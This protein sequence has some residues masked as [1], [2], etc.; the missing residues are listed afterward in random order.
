VSD[1]VLPYAAPRAAA[2]PRRRSALGGFL[3]VLAIGLGVGL[4]ATYYSVSRNVV[5]GAVEAGPWTAWPRTGALDADP[6]TRASVARNGE[7]PLGLGEGLVFTARRDSAGRPLLA[8]C[9]YRVVGRA[10]QARYWTITAQT[11]NGQ[12][13]DNPAGRYGFTS[14]EIVRG[15]N[16]QFAIEVAREARPGAWLPVTGAGRFDLVMRLYDTPVSV[17]SRVI[18][19]ATAPRI[20]QVGC[21]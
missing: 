5:F 16:G 10:P 11:P 4:G 12:L 14:A 18:D 19:P 3:A 9:A 15:Q 6:Y 7:T 21:S 1:F 2:P 20:E 8:Q 13:I 17:T